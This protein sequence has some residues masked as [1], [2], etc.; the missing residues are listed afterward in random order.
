[1][2]GFGADGSWKLQTSIPRLVH[3]EQLNAP[4]MVCVSHRD[5]IVPFQL[6]H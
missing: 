2:I 1:M 3:S 6:M 5:I 4:S